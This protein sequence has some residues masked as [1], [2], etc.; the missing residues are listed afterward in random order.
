MVEAAISTSSRRVFQ[1][2]APVCISAR[3]TSYNVCYT[4]LLRISVLANDSDV[5]MK[6]EL[7]A[8]PSAESISVV[9]T[10][11]GLTAPSHRN[12]FV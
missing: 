3:I 2:D 9:I 1:G 8:D 12:N 7:N 4:K 10:G 11:A 6:E 5:D